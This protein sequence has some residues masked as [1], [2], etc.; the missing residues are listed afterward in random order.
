MIQSASIYKLFPGRSLALAV[1]ALAALPAL[2][3]IAQV[4]TA[5]ASKP[6]AFEVVSIRPAN[7]ESPDSKSYFGPTPDGFRMASLPLVGLFQIAY[8]PTGMGYSGFFRGARISG[9]PD[10]LRADRFDVVAK[11]R[12]TH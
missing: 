12:N 11:V 4:Q 8:V 2:N 1:V 6:L 9:A 10:W 7:P 5:S 3:A